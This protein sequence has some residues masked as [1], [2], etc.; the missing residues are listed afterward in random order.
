MKKMSIMLPFASV[1]SLSSENKN[2]GNF[3]DIVGAIHFQRC[4]INP[5]LNKLFVRQRIIFLQMSM[6]LLAATLR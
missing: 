3:H 4:F 5:E 2:A 6:I 1:A